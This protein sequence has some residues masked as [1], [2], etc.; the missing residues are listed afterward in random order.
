MLSWTL[1]LLTSVITLARRDLDLA[2]GHVVYST[3]LGQEIH[4]NRHRHHAHDIYIAG[5]FP[6]STG[7]AETS[8]GP[9]VTTLHQH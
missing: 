9:G 8:I 5:F 4:P 6:T 3:D 2:P 7:S 1:L